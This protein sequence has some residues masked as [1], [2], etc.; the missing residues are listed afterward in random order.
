MPAPSPS[1]P[2]AAFSL[3]LAAALI[4]P[5]PAAIKPPPDAL[6]HWA[7]QAPSSPEP[8]AASDPSLHPIDRFLRASLADAG[9]SP[10]TPADSR[11][12]I[13]RISFDLTG[14]PPS[15]VET[16]AF[17]Q[18]DAANRPAAVAALTDRLLASPAFGERWGRHWL[19]LAR[20]SDTKGYV[21]GRE[22][23]RF[24][25]A[26][27]YRRWVISALN[28]DLPYNRFLLL[29]IAGDQ[30]LPPASPDL[31]AMGFLT[32]GRRFIGV[33][34]DII[35]DRIDV[36]MRSTMALT[37]QCA[38][39]HDHKYDPVPTADYYSLYG[40]FQSSTEQLIPLHTTDDAELKK[41][42][43]A[44]AS[45]MASHRADAAQRLRSRLADYLN[46]QRELAKY[47]EEGFDQILS[48]SDLIPASVR[49]W[50]DW[51]RT[52]ASPAHPIFGPWLTL[53]ALPADRFPDLAA[54]ALAPLLASGS[55]HPAIAAAFQPPPDSPD[56]VASRYSE[57][58][59]AAAAHP[60]A[61][62]SA[63]LNDLLNDPSGP[64]Q[65]PAT[66]IVNNELFFP[67]DTVT[68]L[69][70]L[71]GDVDRR[72][73][74]LNAPA[75]LTLTDLP[76]AA[77]PRIFERGSPA[78]LGP[79][80]PRQ[81][82][83]I[84]AP[85]DRQ[86]FQS[87]SGRLELANAIASPQNPL[88]ARVFVNRVWQHLFGAGLVRTPSDFGLRAGSPSHPALLD[89]L[90]RD[91]IQSGWSLKS[92]LR[93]LVAS[94]AY[95]Q[96]HSPANPDAS[97]VLDADNHLLSRAPVRR[98]DF[99]AV[100]DAMLSVSGDLEPASGGP[101]MEITDPANRRRTVHAWIDRQFVPGTLRSFDFANPDI[102]VATRHETTVPQQALF[103][104]NGPFASARARSLAAASAS[105]PDPERIQFLHHQLYQRPA[106]AEESAS[107]L[108]FL[109]DAKA[110][111]DALPPPP[112]PSPWSCGTG[113][114]DESSQRTAAFTPL[115]HFT[116]SAYQG[117]PAWPGGPTGWAQLTAT[118]GHP[119]NTRQHAVVRRWTAPIS[120][121]IT[122]T[123]TL[124][125]EPAEGD[126]IRAFI[127]SSR[128][129]TLLTADV[130]HRDLPTAV[131]SL[132]V[133]KGDTIDFLVDIRNELNSDQFLW[134]PHISTADAA[135]RADQDFS[136]PATTPPDFLDPW[137]Q[138]A[139]V[140]LLANE[141][142]FTD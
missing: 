123:G 114:F 142:S 101:P 54:K 102:H 78:R 50:R 34:H 119:G 90:A 63:A 134:S 67:S 7:F 43:D 140:L 1:L 10:A 80:V 66:G 30:L 16:I 18:A 108:T 137:A 71:Q 9:L 39:C 104:L 96:S 29:Q 100:R 46:A 110:D 4:S 138:Y 38:R 42:Q 139:Q 23:R 64:F 45:A 89:W 141:F 35:D 61:P 79:E 49:R 8:P 73:I 87:G 3:F 84:L 40:V 56:A 12:L 129:G 13:R 44:L 48:P 24:A 91:F 53:A 125:H 51:L 36:V 98:L 113:S 6:N 62:G 57:V 31:A 41:R 76:P 58:F 82:P 86:P 93:N 85:H 117:T 37:I 131:P 15:P 92:L 99:E 116:G 26:P 111:A 97:S 130:H 32:G 136:G 55:L 20:Y 128:H 5:A 124:R 126:G 127:I 14:L 75:A 17:S 70:K 121:T 21:Y 74:E 2:R 132:T 122:I 105:L 47:P 83:V 59:N 112:P 133:T 81:L 95:Q 103:F 19:D 68:A 115:P 107:A 135:W 88:T 25:H 22:E 69:W 72:L 106:S 109:A 60:D 11:S 77:N 65:V 94:R 120:A 118:G 33:T 52:H 28:Q 27:T